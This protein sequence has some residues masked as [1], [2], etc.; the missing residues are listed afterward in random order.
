MNQLPMRPTGLTG[1]KPLKIN[2]PCQ[3]FYLQQLN[4]NYFVIPWD[5]HDIRKFYHQCDGSVD[6]L[7]ALEVLE[8]STKYHNLN[9]ENLI[10]TFNIKTIWQMSHS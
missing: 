9:T 7:A 10:K 6:G 1:F 4:Y 8:I 5:R 2:I 3:F